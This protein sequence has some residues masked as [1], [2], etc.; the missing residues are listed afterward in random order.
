MNEIKIISDI[1][2]EKI[3]CSNEIK[4]KEIT[5]DE[6]DNIYFIGKHYEP[7]FRYYINDGKFVFEIQLCCEIVDLN[8]VQKFLKENEEFLLLLHDKRK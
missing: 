7:L 8:I 6:L 5:T 2:N 3:I 4:A 1:N